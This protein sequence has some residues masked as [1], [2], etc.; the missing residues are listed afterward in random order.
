MLKK[1]LGVMLSVV[2]IGG[3]SNHI[4]TIVGTEKH[5]SI[6]IA[7]LETGDLDPMTCVVTYDQEA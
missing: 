2:V 3:V 6:E 7:G 5:Q 1:I 4:N